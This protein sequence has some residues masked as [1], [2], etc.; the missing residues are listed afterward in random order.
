MPEAEVRR[1]E[2]GV[3]FIVQRSL[4]VRGSG[5]GWR[6]K[7]LGTILS[8]RSDQDAA[9][10]GCYV[11]AVE[12]HEPKYMIKCLMKSGSFALRLPLW[13]RLP[14]CLVK[15]HTD[16]RQIWSWFR[17]GGPGVGDASLEGSPGSLGF[18]LPE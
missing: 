15:S 16:M 11:Q 5:R 2:L 4:L 1:P 10:L 17:A 9:G 14:K 18:L 13:L 7:A 12:Q 8:L 3:F 6:R